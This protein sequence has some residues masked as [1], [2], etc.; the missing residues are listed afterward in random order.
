MYHYH[1]LVF[2]TSSGQELSSHRR[3]PLGSRPH[4]HRR[5]WKHPG[6]QKISKDLSLSIPIHEYPWISYLDARHGLASWM[7]L[8]ATSH[9]FLLQILHLGHT[10]VRPSLP[11]AAAKPRVTWQPWR[12]SRGSGLKWMTVVPPCTSPIWNLDESRTCSLCGKV[13]LESLLWMMTIPATALDPR[14]LLQAKYVVRV[15]YLLSVTLGPGTSSNQNH[16]SKLP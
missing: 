16:R 15:H 13:W 2:G 5:L 9:R 6:H 8:D 14:L 11:R 3:H 7:I 4:T 12:T 10:P 1:Q